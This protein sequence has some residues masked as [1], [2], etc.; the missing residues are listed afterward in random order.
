[1]YVIYKTRKSS[2]VNTKRHTDRGVSSTTR[3]GYAVGNKP[4]LGNK[5]TV[6]TFIDTTVTKLPI[7]FGKVCE[8]LFLQLDIK[9]H[10]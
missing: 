7:L 2:C 8:R 5:S 3:G 10:V 9:L 6:C 4:I 1:M